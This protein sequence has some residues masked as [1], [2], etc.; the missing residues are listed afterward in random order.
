MQCSIRLI[1]AICYALAG[2]QVGPANA[3]A[4]Q[5]RKVG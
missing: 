1:V 3:E 2:L 5:D 4:E